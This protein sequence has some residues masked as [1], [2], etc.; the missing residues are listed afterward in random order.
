MCN[1]P[2]EKNDI[3]C[4]EC[5]AWFHQECVDIPEGVVVASD[6]FTFLCPRC[7]K[8]EQQRV[9]RAQ[10]RDAAKQKELARQAAA[11]MESPKEAEDDG[12]CLFEVFG[13]APLPPSRLVADV[14]IHCGGSAVRWENHG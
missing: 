7:Q 4:G 2:S 5:C 13:A 8:K 10:N 3:Q 12:R 9:V 6:E 14:A 11:A 1:Q